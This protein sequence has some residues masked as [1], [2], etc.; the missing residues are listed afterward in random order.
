M[1]FVLLRLALAYHNTNYWVCNCMLTPK[2]MRLLNEIRAGTCDGG[3]LQDDYSPRL[4]WFAHMMGV[5]DQDCADLVQEVFLTAI[6]QIRVGNFKQDSC[7]ITWLNGI[8]KHKIKDLWRSLNRHRR[9]FAQIERQSN[10]EEEGQPEY[11]I[12]LSSRWDSDI[13][14][15]GALNRMP[16]DLC[17]ILLLNELGGLTVQEI[18]CKLQ[19][20][21]GTV[22]RKLAAAKK[23]FRDELTMQH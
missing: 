5:R 12:W 17:T 4:V 3:I 1:S 20:P 7:L 8:L 10:E 11:A 13:D 6:R 19:T 21:A 22:G 15:Q 2:E 9:V 23:M 14:V 18:S 16:A